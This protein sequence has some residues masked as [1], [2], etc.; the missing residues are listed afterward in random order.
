[1]LRVCLVFFR[2]YFACVSLSVFIEVLS[3]QSIYYSGT[4]KL[5]VTTRDPRRG[6]EVIP[7]PDYI[8]YGFGLRNFTPMMTWDLGIAK[9]LNIVLGGLYNN[10]IWTVT[11]GHPDP[12]HWGSCVST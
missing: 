3:D 2:V 9:Q 8:E 5:K 4:R 10:R 1:M 6:F 7:G 12:I 11:M